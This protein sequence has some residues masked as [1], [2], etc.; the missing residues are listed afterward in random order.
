MASGHTAVLKQSAIIRMPPR[1][2]SRGLGLLFVCLFVLML[3]C[4][5]APWLLGQYVASA[6]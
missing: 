6:R 5:V 4:S 1:L 2:G 3:L